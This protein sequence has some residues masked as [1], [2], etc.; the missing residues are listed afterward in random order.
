MQTHGGASTWRANAGR[1]HY[2]IS[3]Q[4]SVLP[5]RPDRQTCRT[6]PV[7]GR[8]AGWSSL[9]ARQAHNLKVVGSNPTPATKKPRYPNWIAGFLISVSCAASFD[10]KHTASGVKPSGDARSRPVRVGVDN[11]TN[12]ADAPSWCEARGGDLEASRSPYDGR[13]VTKGVAA[14]RGQ[15]IRRVAA[16]GGAHRKFHNLKAGGDRVVPKSLRQRLAF[17]SHTQTPGSFSECVFAAFKDVA[18]GFAHLRI[19]KS[20]SPISDAW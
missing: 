13:R 18:D 16:G 10:R 2:L 4:R 1:R 8:D 20:G 14:V 6:N 11:R 7:R 19:L 15:R 12:W 5:L 9:V 17:K 3:M